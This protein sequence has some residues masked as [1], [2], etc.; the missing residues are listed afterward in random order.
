M[1]P[2][3]K[4]ALTQPAPLK[5]KF[6]IP[7]EG[8]IEEYSL[9]ETFPDPFTCDPHPLCLLA[10]RALQL[11][12]EG[13]DEWEHN[14][15][16]VHGQE[17][18]IIGK[19]FGVLVVK[20]EQDEI[21]YLAAFSGKLAG[22]N[23]HAK[24]VPPVFDALTEDSFL[25]TGMKELTRIN[26]QI[27]TL[28]EFGTA[29]SMDKVRILQT[30]RK[31]KSAALQEQLFDQY[32]FLNKAG[33]ERSLYEIFRKAL[34]TRPPSGSGE[35]AAPKL[36]QYAFRYNMKPLAMA[37]FWWGLSPKSDSWKH[38]HF[39]PACREKC[40]PILAYMLADTE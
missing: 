23:H 2:D 20:N 8:S 1:Q 39:Y 32:H 24:F 36:L 9:P 35:C 13:Q 12:L 34:H 5:D 33:Q 30:L 14:F 22:S 19:M 40:G 7:F 21:G 25:N 29:E 11:Y 17:G 38:G 28:E 27:N 10:S 31:E 6:F 26:Q 3:N 4:T 37:E 15:G 18:V 16:L